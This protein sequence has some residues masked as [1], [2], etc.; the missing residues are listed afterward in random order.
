ML[1]DRGIAA[2]DL[3][4][5]SSPA[6]GDLDGH[7]STSQLGQQQE[8]YAS[9]TRRVNAPPKLDRKQVEQRIEE[10]RERHKRLR[11]NIW[12]V[13]EGDYAE[14]DKLWEE[15]SDFGDDDLRMLEEEA[16]ELAQ[17]RQNSCVHKREAA[18]KGAGAANGKRARK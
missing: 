6:N 1:K 16:R 17:A 3:A 11:E 18:T 7:V 2:H 13:P 8:Q 14:L 9:S 10:D 4:L 5:A 12:A 15:T